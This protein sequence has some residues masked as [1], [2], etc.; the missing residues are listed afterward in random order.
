MFVFVFVVVFVIIVC[1][2]C[3]YICL[4]VRARAGKN[5]DAMN[6]VIESTASSIISRMHLI[7][8]P[9]SCFRE[10]WEASLLPCD[11]VEK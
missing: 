8:R 9:A 4:L 6:L 1:C 7:R 10:F 3:C 5:V 2:H 11:T